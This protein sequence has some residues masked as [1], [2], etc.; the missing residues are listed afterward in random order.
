EHAVSWVFGQT[1]ISYLAPALLSEEVCVQTRLINFT[2][3]SLQLE[4]LM[5][6][7]NK[8]VLKSV[9]WAKLVHFDLRTRRS[10]VHSPQ[11]M[12]LFN[13]IVNPLQEEAS[14]EQRV[15]ILK[16]KK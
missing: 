7:N 8:S 2:D 15:N 5:F 16:D 13:E 11:L 6:D 14:F 3:K 4:A 12:E 1:Q 10:T 9:M